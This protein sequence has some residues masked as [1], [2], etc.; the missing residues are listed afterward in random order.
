M[1]FDFENIR[2]YSELSIIFALVQIKCYFMKKLFCT[3]ISLVIVLSLN[4]QDLNL[5][6]KSGNFTIK[7]GF[8]YK[9][10]NNDP[11]RIVIF[12]KIPTS[13]QNRA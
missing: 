7:H 11:Y 5:K 10:I 12:K 3:I 2:I 8:D 6:L 9:N 1:H 13:E 4:S